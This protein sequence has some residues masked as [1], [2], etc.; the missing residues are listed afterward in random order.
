MSTV[1][2]NTYTSFKLKP[3]RY[4]KV[5]Q[6]FCGL[7]IAVLLYYTV[8][9]WIGLLCLIILGFSLFFFNQRPDIEQFEQLDEQI[10]SIKYF[11]N[12]L[13]QQVKIIKMV[14]H[15]MYVVIY[16]EDVLTQNKQE[17]VVVWQDQLSPQSW[18]ILKTQARLG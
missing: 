3:S 2:L 5:F 8:V 9:V 13:I 6:F 15:M 10:W 1:N 7:S 12:Q 17:N 16:C 14:D 4:R 11:Q 18:K